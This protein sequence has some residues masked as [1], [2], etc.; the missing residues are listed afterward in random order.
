MQIFQKAPRKGHHV[1]TASACLYV[2]WMITSTEGM[3]SSRLAGA[4]SLPLAKATSSSPICKLPAQSMLPDSLGASLAAR[5]EVESIPLD[6]FRG[7]PEGQ[8]EFSYDFHTNHSAPAC[9]P[10][11]TLHTA[12]CWATCWLLVQRRSLSPKS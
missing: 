12:I 6:R 8:A 1:M 7:P 5:E 3:C 9:K 10:F 2:L 11:S 4:V